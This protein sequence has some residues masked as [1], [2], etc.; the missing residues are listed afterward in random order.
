MLFVLWPK[1]LIS[2]Q[3]AFLCIQSINTKRN[4]RCEN[5][6]MLMAMYGIDSEGG[7]DIPQQGKSYFL[8]LLQQGALEILKK[9]PCKFK[10]HSCQTMRSCLSSSSTMRSPSISTRKSAARG[11]EQRWSVRSLNQRRLSS[12][13]DP[14]FVRF[15]KSI[16][17][18]ESDS[19]LT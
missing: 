5:E 9:S 15:F 2:L 16:F 18:V 10:A 13:L 19:F 14:T 17:L 8:D 7:E 12:K 6:R 3:N 11:R 4:G 1:P